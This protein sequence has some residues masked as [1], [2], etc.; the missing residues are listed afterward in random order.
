M[1]KTFRSN[2]KVL[3]PVLWVVIAVFVLAIFYDFGSI[4]T[5][6]GT[7]GDNAATA[8]PHRVTMAE[9]RSA[10]ANAEQQ[11]RQQ[12]G[13]RFDPEM[14]R[15]MGL[16][17]Q[18][19]NDLIGQKILLSEA[20]ELGLAATDGEVRE[21]IL[22]IPVFQDETGRFV[23]EERY[24]EQLRRLRLD[25]GTFEEDI[26]D[27]IVLQKLQQA[28]QANVY[29]S[30]KD[31]ERA[32][33]DT[34]EKAKVR[35]VRLPQGMVGEVP[36]T[37]QE[38]AAYFASQKDRFRLPEKRQLAYLL[39]E[40]GKMVGR[41]APSEAEVRAYYDEHADEFTR[42]EQVRARHVLVMID[43]DTP[44]A[45]A[46]AKVEAARRR[47]EAGEDFAKV[48]AEV[49]EDPSNKDKGGDLGFFGRGAMVKEF[50]DAAFGAAPGTLVGPVRTSFGYHLLEKLEERPA[51]RTTLAEAR[52]SIKARLAAE[53][54]QEVARGKAEQ[55]AKQL[56]A[57]APDAPED[58]QALVGGDA[59]VRFGTTPP[60]GPQDPV[61]GLG[62]APA[63]NTAAFGLAE[64]GVSQAVAVPGGWAVL[65]V[66]DVVEP[67]E[68]A[69]A[70]VEPQ[71]RAALVSEKQQ[72]VARQRLAQG[73]QQLTQGKTLDDVAAGLG[74]TVD[75]SEEFGREGYVTNLG[76]NAELAKQALAMEVGQV[77][78][79]VSDPN[80]AVLFQVVERKRWD[81]REFAKAKTETRERLE[82][83]QV[84]RLM[85][86]VIEKRRRDLDLRYDAGLLEAL[87][88]TDAAQ[89]S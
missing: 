26:R 20:R 54:V 15:R 14:M 84:G 64:G 55:L 45:A 87:G 61:P 18:V 29:V 4:S 85:Q 1:L 63:L 37:P 43:D 47:I 38:L 53:K 56:A 39:V 22:E 7:G 13:E 79:P 8:G 2:L 59:A 28:L 16:P 69:L 40:T 48:A 3:S 81:P 30:D 17:L 72:E 10:Y 25:P 21:A 12:F 88:I 71:V 73:K 5:P 70:D 46:R 65:W 52:E 51:G 68:P 75:E 60:I 36:V 74:L 83:E 27:S 82:R 77:G 9:F 6:A 44:D 78:G 41:A 32:Y 49:S 24:A 19:L 33:R 76:Q 42:D 57:A 66:Q 11:Y 31:V 50:E 62:Q 86:A 23:G 35:F 80:G 89:A 58:V 34:V 67:R